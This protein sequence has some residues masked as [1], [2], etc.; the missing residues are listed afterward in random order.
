LAP[1]KITSM[2]YF[3]RLIVFVAFFQGQLFAQQFQASVVKRN[4]TPSESK[5]LLG[6]GERKSSGVL[7]SLYHKVVIFEAGDTRFFLI[8]T[9]VCVISP[10]EYDRVAQMLESRLGIDPKNFWW[11]ATHTHSAPEIGPPGLPEAFMGE[12]Y[13]HETDTAYANFAANE[14]VSAIQEGIAT[15]EPA[16]LGVGWGHSMANINRRARDIDDVAF[17]GLNP[18]GPVDR[19]IGLLKIMR[20]SDESLMTL[21]AN[22]PI[23]GTVM[24]GGNLLISGDAPGVVANYVEEKLGVPLLFINGATGN[25]APIYS[26]YPDARS[27]RLNQFRKLLGD[28]ILFAQE[29]ICTFEDDV[30]LK[31]GELIFET[32]LKEGL[33]W[34][35][36]LDRYIRRQ[37]NGPSLV[38]VPVRFLNINEEIGIWGSPLELFCEI[39]NEVREASPFPYTFFYGYTNGWL[40]YLV[41]DEELNYG[42][43]EPSVSPFRPNAANDFQDAVKSYLQGELKSK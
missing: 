20:K 27:G 7:D 24:G 2:N 35:K 16:R 22:Y 14:L 31:V 6:Y 26:V 3:I 39:A 33:V 21:I 18:D 36:D 29:K 32:P 19:R 17:L 10:S 41:T 42:G 1:V 28:K 8:S 38:R 5:Y 4:I 30:S 15:L 34:P 25:L 11:T 43:Y 12:R 23:H 40:G 37:V 13:K 9:D